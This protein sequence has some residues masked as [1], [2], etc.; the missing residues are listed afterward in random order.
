MKLSLRVT[1]TTI[2]LSVNVLTVVA[3]GYNSYRNARFTADDLTRQ[4]LE[5]TS[6]RV[7]QQINDLLLSANEQS[8]LNRALLQTRQFDAH[9]F[10][11][12][13]AYWLEVMKVHPRLTRLSLGLEATGE[14]FYVR[15]RPDGKLAVG[16]LRKNAQTGKL[17]LRDYW[18]EDYPRGK[19][20]FDDPDKT[21]EDPRQ[22]P[23]YLAA[24][25]ARRQAWSE[26][27]V[28]FGTEGFADVPGASCATPLHH[29]DGSLLGVV[30][31]SFDLYEL[32]RHLKDL[33]V[34]QTGY[35]FLVEFRADGS[36]RVIAHPNPEILMR[37][38]QGGKGPNAVT[39]WSTSSS[40]PTV[41]SRRSCE[42]STCPP[43]SS[44]RSGRR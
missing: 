17:G 33:Q 16:E 19:P 5:Q 31:A 3:L 37:V 7:D 1:L 4:I 2:L 24:K 28:F 8:A 30:G 10:P 15:R 41:G 11:G 32:C 26:T 44:R 14:W 27:Y 12:L 20:F 40:W 29:A 35:A 34:G 13:A 43:A 25:E 6:V 38:A 9:A 23:W 39:S 42:A 18:P 21:D 22:R 36:R